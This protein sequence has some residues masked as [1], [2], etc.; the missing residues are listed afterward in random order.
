VHGLEKIVFY[1]GEIDELCSQFDSIGK[2]LFESVNAR[3]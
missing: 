1:Q 2:G 3:V